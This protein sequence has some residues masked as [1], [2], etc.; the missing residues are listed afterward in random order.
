MAPIARTPCVNMASE[1]MLLN[2]QDERFL[3][4]REE[5]TAWDWVTHIFSS[6]LSR[7]AHDAITTSL[8]RQNDVATSCW[9]N[10]DVIIASCAHWDAMIGSNNSLFLPFRNQVIFWTNWWIIVNWTAR[11][12]FPRNLN[13]NTNISLQEKCF[14]KYCLWNFGHFFVASN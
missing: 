2:M 4:A 8:L 10:N 7:Q 11:N 9:R 12:K 13:R 3:S 6:K 1:A 5:Q 14:W